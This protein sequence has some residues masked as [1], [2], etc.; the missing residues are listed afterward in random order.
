MENYYEI[1]KVVNFA[2]DEVIRASHKALV[3]KYHPDINKSVDP[4]IMVKINEA[5]EVLSDLENKKRY[6]TQLK[7]YLDLINQNKNIDVEENDI[8]KNHLNNKKTNHKNILECSIIRFLFAIIFDVI[9]ALIGSYFVIGFIDLEG[10]WSYFAYIIYGAISGMILAN[11]SRMN[12]SVLGCIGII[13][14]VVCMLLPYYQY[15]YETLLLIYGSLEQV[16]HF[17]RS[18][19]EIAHMLL[20]SGII[21]MLM[22]IATPFVTYSAVIEKY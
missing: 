18:T 20:G 22:V 17:V 7:Q 6:D 1:L 5:Y 8:K 2:D 11:I 14:T 13:I 19:Q 9:F 4:N 21:R 15:M 12:N 16:N 3:K 10:S